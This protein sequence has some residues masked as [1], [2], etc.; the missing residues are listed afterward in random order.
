MSILSSSKKVEP[1]KRFHSG[2]G[3]EFLYSKLNR[4][5]PKRNHWEYKV[6]FNSMRTLCKKLRVKEEPVK[7]AISIYVDS[8]LRDGKFDVREFKR[9]VLNSGVV[10]SLKNGDED[11]EK[12]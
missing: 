11:G 1:K 7:K 5:I 3:L 6:V 8:I 12:L 9:F 4:P 2:I 10:S